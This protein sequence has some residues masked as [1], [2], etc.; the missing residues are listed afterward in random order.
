MVMQMRVNDEW[1]PS[2]YIA[3]HCFRKLYCAHNHASQERA[4]RNVSAWR[5]NGVQLALVSCDHSSTQIMP[6]RVWAH[7]RVKASSVATGK[8]CELS[9]IIVLPVH[10]STRRYVSVHGDDEAIVFG[11]SGLN[12]S[13]NRGILWASFLWFWNVSVRKWW[14]ESDRS[15]ICLRRNP[16]LPQLPR[17]AK[18]C[19]SIAMNRSSINSCLLM[20]VIG[21][22]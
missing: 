10:S 19:V 2:T 8:V 14:I 6:K 4:L 15:R 7:R 18:Q 22:R 11:D 1:K 20:F 3:L 21:T 9:V 17:R 5:W 16:H 13:Q 12:G